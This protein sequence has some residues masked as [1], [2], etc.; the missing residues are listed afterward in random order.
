MRDRII[1]VKR[2]VNELLME[3]NP[4]AEA[5]KEIEILEYGLKKSIIAFSQS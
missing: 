1:S 4:R 2:A 5:I 3:L